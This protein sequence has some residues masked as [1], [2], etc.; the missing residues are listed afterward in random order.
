M[1]SANDNEI[2]EPERVQYSSRKTDIKFEDDLL[3]DGLDLDDPPTDTNLQIKTFY[4]S[5]RALE[6]IELQLSS[7][8]KL[9]DLVELIEARNNELTENGEDVN[10]SR[11]DYISTLTLE[12]RDAKQLVEDL[13]KAIIVAEAATAEYRAYQSAKF[14]QDYPEIEA[15]ND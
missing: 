7:T 15:D 5:T 3:N 12:L 14:K 13:Q 8:G 4:Q 1:V 6:R 11:Y 10:W 9:A 2:K